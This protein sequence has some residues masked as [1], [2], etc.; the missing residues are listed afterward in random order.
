MVK[1]V[2]RV[3]F[4]HKYKRV[5]GNECSKSYNTVEKLVLSFSQVFRGSKLR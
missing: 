3:G 5:S 1:G 4:L 2:K